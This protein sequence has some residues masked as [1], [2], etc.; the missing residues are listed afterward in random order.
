M[1]MIFE[2]EGETHQH[3]DHFPWKVNNGHDRPDSSYRAIFLCSC[4]SF[5]EWRYPH[6]IEWLQDAVYQMFNIGNEYRL[7]WRKVR[8]YDRKAKKRIKEKLDAS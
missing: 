5:F 2:G 6:S 4:D 7:S 3:K 1:A 8:W